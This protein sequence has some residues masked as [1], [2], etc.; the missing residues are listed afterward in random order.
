AERGDAIAL[1]REPRR[2]G[3]TAAI[4]EKP[5]LA[6]GDDGGAELESRDRP[7]GA[8]PGAVLERDDAGRAV[9]A[10]LEPARDDADDPGMPALARDEDQRRG[11][12][13]P[14]HRLHGR[15]EDAGL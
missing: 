14:L 15:R 4:D 1:D 5:R 8:L 3:V 12:G 11:H 13:F 10:L 7:A 6:R 2:H 9:V